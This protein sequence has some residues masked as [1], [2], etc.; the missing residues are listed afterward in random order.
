[1]SVVISNDDWL[2]A[3]H[4]CVGDS[5]FAECFAAAQDGSD[6]TVAYDAVVSSNKELK[7]RIAAAFAY[8]RLG[9]WLTELCT[10]C[11][12]ER[13][14]SRDFISAATRQTPSQRLVG[15]QKMVEQDS[16]FKHTALHAKGLIYVTNYICRIVIDG[17]HAGTGL[18]VPPDLVM[19]AGHVFLNQDPLIQGGAVEPHSWERIEVLFDDRFDFIER[20]LVRVRLKPRPFK[21]VENWLLAHEAPPSNAG[22]VATAD[23]DKP[24]Y[25]LVRLAGSP[26]PYAR[27]LHMQSAAPF[28]N[29]PLLIIQH[30]Q[31]SA[32]CHHDGLVKEPITGSTVF[33]HSVNSQ[34]G[35]SGAPCF[36]TNFEVVGVHTGEAIGSDP[37]RNVALG[38]NL[39][40]IEVTRWIA[41]GEPA[42]PY[43]FRCAKGTIHP[44][45]QRE[46]TLDWLKQA[47]TG[48]SSR[49]LAISPAPRCR[50]G[51]SFTADLISALL[52]NAEH[53]VVKLSALRFHSQTPLGF[54]QMLIEACGAPS[55]RDLPLPDGETT[56]V[57]YMRNTLVPELIRK[58]QKIRDGR[59][60]WLILDD[61]RRP[62]DSHVPLSEGT[63]LRECLDLIY[64][65]V[66]GYD[67]LR[68]V[69]LGY[70]SVAPDKI[71]NFWTNEKFEEV[72]LSAFVDYSRGL[73]D[74]IPD[75]GQRN[76][77]GS[78]FD[79]NQQ[80]LENLPPEQQL[81][82]AA[83]YARFLLMNLGVQ[84]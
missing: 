13:V 7:E 4:V 76:G 79:R 42:R 74:R 67:W 55:P 2:L 69:L 53:R 82:I 32:L 3:E 45:V 39:P 84:A 31:G 29:D 47:T 6:K 41:E 58:L 12:S 64:E 44:I 48:D 50:T 19:T 83:D 20:D 61:L 71:K 8:A 57:A 25:A 33:L 75:Q 1:M 9:K 70:D 5:A 62:D 22:G 21:V 10:Q 23:I 43:F 14:V 60:F 65:S 59:L 24:D 77:Y 38:I 18:L 16:P 40:A 28:H 68:I 30:P 63:G 11:V 80:Q 78:L 72:P 66:A 81:P 73:I 34:P 36:N 54:V 26:L 49:I 15:W 17:Q 52:P 27:P 37:A 35:S 56:V 51:M 46:R